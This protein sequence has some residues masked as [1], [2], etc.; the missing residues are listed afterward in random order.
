MPLRPNYKHISL[1]N[2]FSTLFTFHCIFK[3]INLFQHLLVFDSYL[4]VPE[5]NIL[6]NHI[7]WRP[8]PYLLI[9]CSIELVN[10]FDNGILVL[11]KSLQV[12]KQVVLV[13]HVFP[14]KVWKVST[15]HSSK[16]FRLES[17]YI[18][19]FNRMFLIN[20]ISESVCTLPWDWRP[21]FAICIKVAYL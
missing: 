13:C 1:N 14:F 21:S 2:R 5:N 9:Q 11:L 20:I 7:K 18:D 6:L 10:A 17:L 16:S 15:H 4:W 12:F 8:H 19:W 3:F